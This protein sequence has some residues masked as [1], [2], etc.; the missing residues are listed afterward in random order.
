MSEVLKRRMRCAVYT[1]KSTDE[2]LDQEYNSIDAQRDAG[3][4]Y[5]ASQ[6]AEGWIP[7]ADDY[8][9]PAFSGGNMDRPALKRLMADIE[10]GKIDVV[11]IYKIDRLTRS[12]ADFS[13]MV[14]VFERFGVSFVSVTQQFNTTTSMGRLMLNILLSFAQFEREVTGE[15]IRDKIAASKRKG[16]WMGGVPPLGY[17]VENRRLVPNEKE[18]KLIR[19][20]FQRFV[21]LGSGT[22]LFKELKLDGVT[23]KAWTTQDGKT[24]EGKPIDK[25]LIYK[26]LN[27]RTYLGELRHKEQWYQAEHP[28]II[29]RALWDQVHAIL[30]TN[31]RVRGNATRATVP[32]LLKGIVFGNDGRA[33]SPFHTTKKNGRRYRYYVPQRENKEHAGASG[34]PRLPAAELESAVLDQLRSILRSPALLGDVLPRAIELDPSLDEAKVT[35]AMTRLDTIWDQLFPAEQTR[36]VKLLVEKVI[37][38]PNDLEVRLRA[39]GIERLVLEL[40]PTGVAQPEEALA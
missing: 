26:L 6:R 24:R 9:D 25:G 7:V 3:H 8:D 33:L 31:G 17:D 13:K 21:E 5:I 11:V 18:A 14:E 4:A 30:A 20:I 1:R 16:M 36:I 12:L 40:Q 37:V 32:Y 2:G 15:R 22:L 27:N 23:S 39:N 38:S 28:P 29:D 34:L 35:V 10:A 19:H